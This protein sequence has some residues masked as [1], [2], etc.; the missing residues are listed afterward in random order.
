[1]LLELNQ[2]HS[3]RHSDSKCSL[4]IVWSS[5]HCQDA[6]YYMSECGDKKSPGQIEDITQNGTKDDS[7]VFDL[8]IIIEVF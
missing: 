3:I 1:M 7:R 5:K 4:F 2:A 6:T 8:D